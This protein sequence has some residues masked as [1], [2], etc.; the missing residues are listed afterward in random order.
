ML[1]NLKDQVQ[2]TLLEKFAE[3]VPEFCIVHEAVGELGVYLNFA[4]IALRLRLVRPELVRDG[5]A[6][7]E[8]NGLWNI[9]KC[10][11]HKMWI[12]HNISTDLSSPWAINIFLGCRT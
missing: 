4:A 10:Y 3:I 11:H 12:R 7:V 2:R 6:V 8:T 1:S 9:I 5:P